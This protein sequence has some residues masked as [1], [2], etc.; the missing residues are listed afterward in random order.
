MKEDFENENNTNNNNNI[1]ENKKESEDISTKSN[2]NISNSLVSQK[3]RQNV[4]KLTDS[5]LE[6][7]DISEN[8]SKKPKVAPFDEVCSICSSKIYYKKY[9]CIVCRD[10]ILC[11]NCQEEHLHPILECKH[12]QLSQ[13]PDIYLY[14]KNHNPQ[15]KDDITNKSKK[16]GFFSKIFS[17]KFELKLSCTSLNFS[18]RPNKTINIPITIQNLSNTVF[19]C[20]KNN[21]ILFARNNKDLKVYEKK[22]EQVLS[23]QE[24]AD[25]NM[26]LESS[27]FCKLY[28]FTIELYSSEDIKIKYNI[29]S[30]KLEVNNDEEDEKLNEEF[31]KYPKITVMDKNIKK[32]V[33]KILE[34]ETITQDP[35]TIMQFL[36]NNNGDVNETINNLKNMQIK[37]PIFK[38]K[39]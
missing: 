12:I 39:K 37:A 34:D 19:D 14:M 28:S 26:I 7:V 22:V 21:L 24:Q 4:I 1:I 17:G 23:K 6:F 3:N 32:G 35:V 33:K 5:D 9:I 29:L 2:E 10:C 18:T 31:I 36:K 13:V 16:K 25:V 11:Q 20:G 38:N 30:F 27:E 8:F 15:I